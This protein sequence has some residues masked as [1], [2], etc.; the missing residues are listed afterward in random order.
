[1]NTQMIS[2]LSE[3]ELER[4]TEQIKL[5]ITLVLEQLKTMKK[6]LAKQHMPDTLDKYWIFELSIIQ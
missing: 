2:T 6:V 3:A 1:M 5:E 4:R